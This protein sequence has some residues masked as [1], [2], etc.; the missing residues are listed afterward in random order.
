M[1][2]WPNTKSGASLKDELSSILI[3]AAQRWPSIEWSSFEMARS[4]VKFNDQEHP[5]DE[6]ACPEGID[7]QILALSFSD[8]IQLEEFDKLE[9]GTKKL[10]SS[11][12]SKF[13]PWEEKKTQEWFREVRR[14]TF[15]SASSTGGYLDFRGMGSQSP[16]AEASYAHFRLYHFA[17]SLISLCL[18]IHPSDEFQKMFRSL[19]ETNARPRPSIG[20]FSLRRG[21]QE[22]SYGSAVSVRMEEI[23]KLFM[24]INKHVVKFLRQNLGVG[25]S[26]FGPLPFVPVFRTNESLSI[27]PIKWNEEDKQNPKLRS[28]FWH[29]LSLNPFDQYR[30]YSGGSFH[31]NMV[32]R[33]K[34]NHSQYN[35]LISEPDYRETRKLG[36]T[37]DVNHEM[38]SFFRFFLEN[39][40]S[41][42]ALGHL[43]KRFEI[44]II[45]L[46]DILAPALSGQR[47]G[48][49]GPKS[50]RTGF[51][52]L[53]TA[54]GLNY[55]QTRV[56]SEIGENFVRRL[57]RMDLAGVIRRG[58]ENDKKDEF[59]DGLVWRIESASTFNK[60][61]L[62]ILKKSFE[63]MIAYRA[64]RVN[65]RIQIWMTVLTILMLVLT[66]VLLIPETK[67]N[68]IVEE[69][70]RFLQ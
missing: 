29:S 53:A 55:S 6:T 30:T 47:L 56:I 52:R 39:L 26:R 27:F 8:L 25:L 64:S 68:I 49:I 38:F 51:K 7:V 70:F 35:V 63:E 37:D 48:R 15:G 57:L 22:W 58:S 3:R 20:R 1:K 5:W 21:I 4:I 33:A 9:V 23:D 59:V 17:P 60:A 18:T 31:I 2:N 41:L 32:E 34:N 50:L 44:E 46:R 54:N 65:V 36:D 28:S 16:I 61:Q 62:D 14:R 11:Y 10:L 43:M 24:D 19:I 67:R 13:P 12:R 40:S 45:K 42:I 66:F 69:L